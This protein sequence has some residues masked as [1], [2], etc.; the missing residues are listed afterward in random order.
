MS[1]NGWPFTS[2]RW[3]SHGWGWLGEMHSI[4]FRMIR[5]C[6][7]MPSWGCPPVLHWVSPIRGLKAENSVLNPFHP[8]KIINSRDGKDTSLITEAATIVFP[9]QPSRFS[10]RL[11]HS[12]LGML[13][14]GCLTEKQSKPAMLTVLRPSTKPPS[15]VH[16]WKPSNPRHLFPFLWIFGWFFGQPWV[17]LT[18]TCGFGALVGE[19]QVRCF[20]WEVKARGGMLGVEADRL[21]RGRFLSCALTFRCEVPGSF[22]RW[23]AEPGIGAALVWSRCVARTRPVTSSA[24]GSASFILFYYFI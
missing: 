17:P 2:S 16:V 1:W 7:G 15:R 19:P 23:R 21:N 18:W 9:E 14:A 3:G 12:P 13:G 24:S 4:H 11:L 10:S 6:G 5:Q 8:C 20:M 22:G